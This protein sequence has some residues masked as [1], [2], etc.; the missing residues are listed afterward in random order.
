MQV[1]EEGKLV[2]MP[3]LTG[4]PLGEEAKSESENDREAGE[5]EKN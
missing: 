4:N 1:N 2:P 5:E 3:G